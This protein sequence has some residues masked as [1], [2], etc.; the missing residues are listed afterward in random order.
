MGVRTTLLTLA[1]LGPSSAFLLP[2]SRVSS[3]YVPCPNP[4]RHD[5]AHVRP[6]LL[7]RP[8]GRV[9][10]GAGEEGVSRRDMVKT[11]TTA[12]AALAVVAPALVA[13]PK[14]AEAAGPAW[15]QVSEAST[16]WL[17]RCSSLSM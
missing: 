3:R 10:M 4:I 17:S 16:L 12:A 7:P 1:L 5:I 14:A 2:S 8:Q 13:A 11:S 6:L 15:E 9:C